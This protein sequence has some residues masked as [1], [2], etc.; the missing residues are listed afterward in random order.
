M[1][2]ML[3]QL[4]I[5]FRKFREMLYLPCASQSEFIAQVL[6]AALVEDI[7]LSVRDIRA[8]LLLMVD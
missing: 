2:I 6:G 5:S 4:E 8:D 3:L 7:I 1:N